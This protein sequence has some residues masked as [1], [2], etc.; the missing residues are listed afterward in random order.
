MVDVVENDARGRIE[1]AL[2]VFEKYD[3]EL[4]GIDLT[5][6]PPGGRRGGKKRSR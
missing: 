5:G 3:G 6:K 4:D 1:E 2:E